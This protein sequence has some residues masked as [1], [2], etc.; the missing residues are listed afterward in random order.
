VN[1]TTRE[2]GGTL[3]VA[4]VGS[5]MASVCGAHVVHSLTSL[6]VPAAARQSVVAG[7]TTA[8]HLPPAVQG[9]AAQA[10]RQAFVDG[11]S[12]GSLAAAAG[13]AAAAAAALAFLPA[14]ARAPLP[15]STAAPA[16]THGPTGRAAAE[17]S[18]AARSGGGKS[19]LQRGGE[20][21]GIDLPGATRS[22]CAGC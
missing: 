10:A 12:A 11:L 2:L 16:L 5:V 14:R 18:A 8:A 1:D 19:R 15:G 3:G 21:G 20:H 9:P 13:T 7:L 22:L 6:G 17:K 4:V